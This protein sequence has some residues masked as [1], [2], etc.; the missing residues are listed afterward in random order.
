MS[1][2]NNLCAINLATI[3]IPP[4]SLFI[5]RVISKF[6]CTGLVCKLTHMI[7]IFMQ[8]SSFNISTESIDNIKI[9]LPISN[10]RKILVLF[11]RESS[12][13]MGLTKLK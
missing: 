8:D 1:N 11:L 9:N 3:I 5:M 6:Q 2:M 7:D 4:A 12:L 10:K 13:I